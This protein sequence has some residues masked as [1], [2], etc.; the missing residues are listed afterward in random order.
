LTFVSISN[1]IGVYS[2]NKILAD[3]AKSA[4]STGDVAENNLEAFRPSTNAAS[5]SEALN[6]GNAETLFTA[7]METDLPED[8]NIRSGLTGVMLAMLREAQLGINNTT[9]KKY[10]TELTRIGE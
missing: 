4:L 1:P 9:I 6:F 2:I 5:K 8:R 10:K 7:E 3:M